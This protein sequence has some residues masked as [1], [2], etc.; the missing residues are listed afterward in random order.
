MILGFTGT[1]RGLTKH[2]VEVLESIFKE[3][4]P[5]IDSTIHG[6]CI[7]ADETFHSLCLD[8][9]VPRIDVWPSDIHGK[10]GD[11]SGSNEHTQVIL[12]D[13]MPPLVRNAVIVNKCAH[14]LACPG[15][16]VEVQRSGTWSTL[17]RAFKRNIP[18][19]IIYPN[20][21]KES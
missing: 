2:Q 8:Y 14:L 6:G 20:G 11:C 13:E 18:F 4:R 1:Q 7:G 16:L 5:R 9:R 17:R 10:Q 19:T 3:L 21:G 12:H 15:E